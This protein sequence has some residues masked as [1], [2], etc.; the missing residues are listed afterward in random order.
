MQSVPR[1]LKP[2][3][4]LV[5]LGAKEIRAMGV[6][7][8]K[9][10]KVNHEPNKKN[11]RYATIRGFLPKPD[12]DLCSDLAAYAFVEGRLVSSF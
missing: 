11:E 6:K 7:H 9:K 1:R 3:D 5:R 8:T 4:A 10:L 2:N 12:E